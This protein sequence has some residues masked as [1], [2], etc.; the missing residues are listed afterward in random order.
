MDRESAR[1]IGKDRG[2]GIGFYV[3]IYDDYEAYVS[4]CV[5]VDENSRQYSDFSFIAGDFNREENAE[6]LWE[7]FGDGLIDGYAEAWS[8]RPA[9][10]RRDSCTA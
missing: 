2:E 1:S 9:D 10:M 4:E 5:E 8:R 7:S 6:E 3:E